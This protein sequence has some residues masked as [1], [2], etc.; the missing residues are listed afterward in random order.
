M[1]K[2]GFKLLRCFE[3]NPS[4]LSRNNKKETDREKLF[5]ALRKAGLK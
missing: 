5:G 2:P 4:F 1:R 3:Y